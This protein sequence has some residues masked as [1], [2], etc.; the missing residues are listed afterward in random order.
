MNK[1]QLLIWI[2]AAMPASVAAALP[3][4]AVTYIEHG[5]YGAGAAT[6]RPANGGLYVYSTNP[7]VDGRGNV[8]YMIG[9]PPRQNY[10]LFSAKEEEALYQMRADQIA[11]IESARNRA[12]MKRTRFHAQPKLNWPKV[13]VVGDRTCVPQLKFADAA[14]WKEHLVCWNAG[15]ARVE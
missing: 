10:D 14:D 15:D 1:R 11:A 3:N 7:V 13:V 4:D 8:R 2:C 12:R 6:L 5:P 9:K